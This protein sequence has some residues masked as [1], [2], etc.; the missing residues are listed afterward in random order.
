ME[1]RIIKSLVVLG[2]PGVALGVFYLLFKQFGFQ[3]STIGPTASAFIAILFIL[4]IGG[5]TFFALHRWTPPKTHSELDDTSKD[6]KKVTTLI[7]NHEKLSL[8]IH[9]L[10]ATNRMLL[11]E[12]ASSPDGQYVGDLVTSEKLNLSRGEIVYRG[13]DLESKGLIYERNLTDKCFR[14]DNSVLELVDRNLSSLKLLI[15]NIG[16]SNDR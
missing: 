11:M 6:S 5:I 16:K 10:S 14:I 13:K 3:F 2:V 7:N 1:S 9:E 4:I 12:I 8:I 15:Q